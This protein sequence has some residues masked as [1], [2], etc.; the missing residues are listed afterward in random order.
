[1]DEEQ[2]FN[3]LISMAKSKRTIDTLTK[4]HSV[5]RE[6][7][8]RGSSDFT[9]STICRVGK[10]AGIP[11][12]QSIRNKPGECYRILINA[13]KRGSSIKKNRKKRSEFD[14]VAEIEDP[15]HRFLI[16]DLIR[17]NS[18][19]RGELQICKSIKKLQIDLREPET[20]S[21]EIKLTPSEEIALSTSIDSKG[22][23]QKGWH[24]TSRGSIEDAN[25]RT[26]MKNGYV[27]AIEKIL[28]LKG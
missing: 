8:E 10:S 28:S 12:E 9:I 7:K 6:Q 20:E 22:L 11:S 21:P 24:R 3:M 19:L 23:N 15:I 26:I 5:C 18:E 17:A 13:W 4:V 14:W 25:G 2:T 27:S 1:M 16:T